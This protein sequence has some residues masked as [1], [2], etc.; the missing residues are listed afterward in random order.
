[1]KPGYHRDSNKNGAEESTWAWLQLYSRSDNCTP[2]RRAEKKQ[3]CRPLTWYPDRTFHPQRATTG[4]GGGRLTGG[5]N[6]IFIPAGQR[7]LRDVFRVP[8]WGKLRPSV[9]WHKG[10]GTM[11][12][13]SRGFRR[14]STG[15]RAPTFFNFRWQYSR[16]AGAGNHG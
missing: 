16:A 12:V 15:H 6:D 2:S 10:P 11:P 4:D 13:R 3:E 7:T 14:T 1:M 8:S 5:R 9:W